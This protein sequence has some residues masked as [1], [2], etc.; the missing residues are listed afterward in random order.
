MLKIII[1]DPLGAVTESTDQLPPNAGLP[2]ALLDLV[3]LAVLSDA[4]IYHIIQSCYTL[5]I[6]VVG[7]SVGS[8]AAVLLL[9]IIVVLIIVAVVK[10]KRKKGDVN[11]S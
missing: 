3:F 4:S 5:V 2:H 10:F 7:A 9:A 6:A 8:A 1:H 11:F